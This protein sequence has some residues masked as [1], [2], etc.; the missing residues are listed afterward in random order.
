MA[1]RA[2]WAAE[3]AETAVEAAHA[4]DIARRA[5]NAAAGATTDAGEAAHAVDTMRRAA[6]TEGATKSKV[7]PVAVRPHGRVTG[8]LVTL[9]AAMLPVGHRGRYAEE[10]SSLVF[11]LG[12]RRARAGQVVS[13]LTRGAPR[14]AWTLRH[15]PR[16]TPPA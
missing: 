3:A 1:E 16:E 8:R 12:S 15:P 2:R 11:E 5:A 6:A 4:L 9:S 13:I 7:V 14:Q 10:W